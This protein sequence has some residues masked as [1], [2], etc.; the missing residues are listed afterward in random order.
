MHKNN[1]PFITIMGLGKTGYSC[2]CYLAKCKS[3]FA[4]VDNR[5]NPPYLAKF[6]T[7]FPDIPIHL[8][9][10]ETT[11]FDK[12]NELVVSPGIALHEP[13]IA[14]LMQRGCKVIGDI[15]LFA[16]AAQAPIVAITGSNG[17][18][19]VTALVGTMAK[20]AG[21]NVKVGGNFGTPALD[22]LDNSCDLYVLELSSF[23]LET[24]YTLKPA[25]AALLNISPDHMDRYAVLEDYIKAKQHI[26]SNAQYAIINNDDPASFAGAAL[27]NKALSF[28]LTSITKSDFYIA[29][30][31]L[32]HNNKALLPLTDLK[33]KG[34]HQVANALA[35][36]ALGTAVNLPMQAM[37]TALCA[38]TGLPH[39]C[40]WVAN[41][42]DVE[43]YNDSKG[44]NVGA[45]KAAI[46]G[47][48]T[49]IAGKLVVIAGGIGKD[50]DFTL[51]REPISKYVK[52]LVL[53]GK[54]A[55]IIEQAIT[56]VC[57]IHHAN[58]MKQAVELA[59]Q[60]ATAK[61]AVLLSPACASFDMFNNFEHR[62]EVFMQEVNYIA[63]R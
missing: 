34:R 8:G 51:L 14:E 61:D 43:W 18:S 12:T 2:A 39:R 33:I 44:T 38:F 63:T 10:F 22:L 24:T 32:V 50:A 16:R 25:A 30:N 13:K 1:K 21:K 52:A 40:Q 60:K 41:I 17:K 5:V 36:L 9:N 11:I 53:I 27:P 59:H 55:T 4:V 46:E 15:E 26:F 19:T 6:S 28:S 49:E 45:T 29:N 56:G 7:N 23:Q 42:N 37:L 54:D 47:L 35:A 58:S 57:E 20:T 62:G 31:N 48:G 3:N